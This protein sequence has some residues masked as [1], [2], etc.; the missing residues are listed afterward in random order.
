MYARGLRSSIFDSHFHSFISLSYQY[1]HN[2]INVSSTVQLSAPV[3]HL[4]KRIGCQGSTRIC[5]NAREVPHELCSSC[6][7]SIQHYTFLPLC[8][9]VGRFNLY[10]ISIFFAIKDCVHP[11]THII[12]RK[13]ALADLV[14]M[15]LFW[16]WHCALIVQFESVAERVLFVCASHFT[17]GILHVHLSH[18]ATSTFTEKEEEAL[19]FSHFSWE[20]AATSSA[21]VMNTGS[22]EDLSIKSSTT[23]SSASSSQF[24]QGPPFRQG[25]CRK[26]GIEY[27][28]ICSRL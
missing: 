13:R 7:I 3:S 17:V 18:L 11:S 20:R 16:A 1:K 24:A 22:M 2:P 21:C 26:H 14:G 6:L 8:V 27:L 28:G 19:V 10:A 4:R 5:R 15:G 12:K 25:D 23:S 9:L